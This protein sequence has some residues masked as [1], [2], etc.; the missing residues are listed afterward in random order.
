MG[1]A[2]GRQGEREKFI[3]QVHSKSTEKSGEGNCTQSQGE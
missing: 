1:A 3:C 2:K